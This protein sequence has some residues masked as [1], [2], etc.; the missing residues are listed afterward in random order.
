[1]TGRLDGKVAFVTGAARGVGRSIA[2]RLAE[3]GADVIA[4]D[5][6]APVEDDQQYPGATEDD[7]DQTAREVE[8]L[9]R[10]IVARR[11]DVRDFAAVQATVDDGVAEL[12][13]VD[14]VAAN[15]GSVRMGALTHETGEDEW[16]EM[17]GVNLT[18]AWN[19]ARAAIPQMIEQGDGGSIVITSSLAGFKGTPMVGGYTAAKH[20]VVGLMRT[21]ALELGPHS[22]R[23][24]SIHP[25]GIDTMM[26]LNEAWYRYFLPELESPT[27]ADYEPIMRRINVLPVAVVEPVDIANAFLFLASD[28]ARYIT[29]VTLPVDAGAL[30]K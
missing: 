9:G 17:I 24:N 5:I 15:A 12:G 27:R 30:A 8:A 19:T 23:V 13:R 4:L 28:E 29:G 2:V 26:G 25:G 21:L 18:G 20:G 10:R 22:I 7:L 11:A 1:M 14:V 6:C 16:E 3:E